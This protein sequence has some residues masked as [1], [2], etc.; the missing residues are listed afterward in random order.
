MPGANWAPHAPH[1]VAGTPGASTLIT[2]RPH[3]GE[4]V[5]AE[6]AR[7]G[8]GCEVDH[9]NT[10]QQV[11]SWNPLAARKAAERITGGASRPGDRQARSGRVFRSVRI[12]RRPGDANGRM[13][14]NAQA[15]P[16]R[17]RCSS[18]STGRGG[19]AR[20]RPRS[21]NGPSGSRRWRGLGLPIMAGHVDVRFCSNWSTCFSSGRFGT[22]ALASV[23]ISVFLTFLFLSAFGG[24]LRCGPGHDV[25]PGR[26]GWGIRP[27]PATC[28]PPSC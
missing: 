28:V 5:G 13:A 20:N 23:G 6:R 26:R 12:A 27:G 11:R 7:V 17:R 18:W 19:S 1:L 10:C 21:H 2:S 3:E 9:A 8:R 24:T 16:R 15:P 4:L 14:P 22:T 25:A